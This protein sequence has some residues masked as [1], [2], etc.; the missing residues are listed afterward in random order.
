[1]CSNLLGVF[2]KQHRTEQDKMG[3][4]ELRAK[5]LILPSGNHVG[6]RPVGLDFFLGEARN[7]NHYE[8]FLNF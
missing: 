2:R 4:E 6:V 5:L 8:E 3:C 1:M 7:P